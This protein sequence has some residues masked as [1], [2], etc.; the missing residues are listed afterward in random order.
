VKTVREG[1]SGKTSLRLVSQKDGFTG[2]A[3]DASDKEIAR[4]SG[5]D[6]DKVWAQLHAEVTKSDPN[7]FGY[8]GAAARFLR[9]FPKGFQS[10]A[11]VDLERAYK[12]EAKKRLDTEAP[13]G[14]IGKKGGFG[15]SALA[16]FRATNLLS[17]YEK[18]KLQEP[19]RGKDADKIVQGIARFA[20]GDMT[21]LLELDR[22]LRPHESAKWTVVTYLPFLWAPDRHMFL[23]PEV[24]KDFATRVGHGFAD[25]YESA[26]NAKVYESLLDLVSSTVR[27]IAPL[28]PRDFIDMQSFIWVVGEYR[29]DAL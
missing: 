13:L 10:K 27:E 3:F 6:A 23:K 8:D 25:I 5:Q 4:V 22:L 18:V 28:K 9:L 15:E 16:A 7:F 21:S 17:P 19:L 26:L 2:L 14:S 29:D 24:T 12:L 20:S 11:F 1:T